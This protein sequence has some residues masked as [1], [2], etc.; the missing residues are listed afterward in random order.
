MFRIKPIWCLLPLLAA[1]ACSDLTAVEERQPRQLRVSPTTF[2]GTEGDLIDLDVVVLD[3]HGNPFDRFPAWAVPLWETSDSTRLIPEGGKLRAVGS[4]QV[5]AKAS[6]AGISAEAIV[7][8]NPREL[9]AGVE[10]VYLTQATQ[11]LDASVPLVAGRPALLR[12]F[13]TADRPNFMTSG[14]R[15]TLHLPG[16]APQVLNLTQGAQIIPETVN[17]GSLGASWNATIPSDL[18]RPGLSFSVE[19]DPAGVLPLLP[20]SRVRHPATGTAPVNVQTMRP[21]RMVMIPVSQPGIAP[22][23]LHQGNVPDFTRELLAM[24]PIGEHD[25]R[26]REPFHSGYVASSG[27]AWVEMLHE[28]W[29]LRT[30][31]GSDAYYYGV[32]SPPPGTGIAGIGYVGLP[33]SLGF[34]RLPEAA[35][36]LAHEIGHNMGR[37]HSPCGGPTGV[38]PGY[39]YHNANL[40]TYGFDVARGALISP[41]GDHRDLMSYC[42]PRWISDYTYHGALQF[43]THAEESL[44]Q[45]SGAPQPAVLVWGGVHRGELTVNPAFTLDMPVREPRGGG[46]Y[47]VEGYDEAGAR[48]FSYA[49]EPDEI[50]HAPDVR[51]F[52]FAIPAHVAQPERLSRLR[53]V[54]PEGAAERRR[55]E[56]GALAPVGPRMQR[57]GT[58]RTLRTTWDASAHPMALIRDPASGRILSF[59]RGGEVVL[60]DRV[61]EVDVL[62][63]DGVRTTRSR[64]RLP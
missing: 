10:A 5:R 11:R 22:P 43:R 6:L 54:G 40:G 32:L 3:Q 30:A 17:Q 55:A 45:P 62:L 31:E 12:V 42:R 51:H 27:T 1:G 61:G 15:V 9:A 26:I 29:A 13:V 47:R 57:I 36:T 64:Y 59:G 58:D 23:H 50:D 16:E 33:A 8:L 4:G 56:P 49:F 21:F 7:R 24:F 37:Y 38:D 25:V 63:S 60:P 44:T 35:G 14:V 19:V 20:Q 34:D 39:P 41:A 28:L 2:L 53:L 48:L 18:V 46:R 52:A